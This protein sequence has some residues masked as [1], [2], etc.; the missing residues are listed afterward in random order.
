[1]TDKKPTGTYVAWQL[2]RESS[3]Q[4]RQYCE[5]MGVVEPLPVGEHHC[6]IVCDRVHE[7]P[8]YVYGDHAL[9]HPYVRGYPCPGQNRRIEVLGKTTAPGALVVLLQSTAM[10]MRYDAMKS[11]GIV[12][13][14]KTYK[15]HISL[16]YA[17]DKQD[18]NKILRM[19]AYP[20]SMTLVFDHE[21]VGRPNDD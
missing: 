7:L 21:H 19:I 10:S 1:M 17:F 9:P 12:S 18:P 13:D 3:E 5:R 2:A 8:Q 6:T 4:L 20:P 14:F 16:S 11:R 15:P